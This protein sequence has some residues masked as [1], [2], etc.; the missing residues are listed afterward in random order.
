MTGSSF[1][2]SGLAGRRPVHAGGFND[3]RAC[4]CEIGLKQAPE[5]KNG[6]LSMKLVKVSI[7]SA[8]QGDE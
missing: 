6:R 8:P 1:P 2:M 7:A 5:R 4:W 3:V